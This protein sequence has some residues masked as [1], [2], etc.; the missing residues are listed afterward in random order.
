MRGIGIYNYHC[1]IQ[2]SSGPDDS[3][4]NEALVMRNTKGS[5]QGFSR[6][7]LNATVRNNKLRRHQN[8]PRSIQAGCRAPRGRQ[9]ER[10]FSQIAGKVYELAQHGSRI[11]SFCAGGDE[12]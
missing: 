7:R 5:N 8:A 11:T 12:I 1:S 10:A 9:A 6:V 3:G 2:F 4:I